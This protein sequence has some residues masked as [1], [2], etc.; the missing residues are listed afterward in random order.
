[1]RLSYLATTFCSCQPRSSQC[2]MPASNLV[3][4]SSSPWAFHQSVVPGA[5]V[6]LMSQWAAVSASGA[7]G[8]RR[9]GLGRFIWAPDRYVLLACRCVCH[10]LATVSLSGGH[11][12]GVSGRKSAM[13]H[14][15]ASRWRTY[16]LADSGA[17]V[18]WSPVTCGGV[19]YAC[20]A[21]AVHR[22]VFSRLPSANT[23]RW[24]RDRRQT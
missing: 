19:F 13:P 7:E 2:A 23:H 5:G 14:S 20:G 18:F 8:H 4:P 1:M 15:L 17:G 6:S 22:P 16:H 10:I 21:A 11:H 9:L 12:L 24:Q 3:C